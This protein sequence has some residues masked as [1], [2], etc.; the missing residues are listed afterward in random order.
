MIA[1]HENALF[2]CV[3]MQIDVQKESALLGVRGTIA[4]GHALRQ[5][6]GADVEIRAQRH[7][8]RSSAERREFRQSVDLRHF[9]CQSHAAV[10][11][12]F[13]IF[14]QRLLADASARRAV[15]IQA[16]RRSIGAAARIVTVQRRQFVVVFV[17]NFQGD[18]CWTRIEAGTRG[19][20][21][22]GGV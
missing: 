10:L 12:E 6:I 16:Q 3:P 15:L 14:A 8:I 19:V 1:V 5:E 9:L 22:V 17:H 18:F 4:G 11:G 21:L 2:R 13:H 20:V 7:G